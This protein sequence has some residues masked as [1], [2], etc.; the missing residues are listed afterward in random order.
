MRNIYLSLPR[1]N[2]NTYMR[3]TK[4]QCQY[5]HKVYQEAISRN[6]HLSLPRGDNIKTIQL[7]LP[8]DNVNTYMKPT[9][10]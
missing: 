5:I 2:V 10:R 9:K 1:A 3:P 7:S 6:I 8:R 4:R